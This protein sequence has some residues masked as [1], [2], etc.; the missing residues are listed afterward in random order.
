MAY[1]LRYTIRLDNETIAKIDYRALAAQL[2]WALINGVGDDKR[3]KIV[4]NAYGRIVFNGYKKDAWS[5]GRMR[6]L[7]DEKAE[8]FSRE[9]GEKYS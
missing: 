7:F 6:A 1:T 4:D 8:Q 2:A 3:V 9:Y 5:P